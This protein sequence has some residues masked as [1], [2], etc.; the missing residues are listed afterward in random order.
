MWVYKWYDADQQLLLCLGQCKSQCNIKFFHIRSTTYTI[1]SFSDFK[2]FV[3]I[4]ACN[5]TLLDTITS[6]FHA[7][8]DKSSRVENIVTYLACS[9]DVVQMADPCSTEHVMHRFTP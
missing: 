5:K 8:F 4:F 1:R 3:H 9:N 2:L 6:D 7:K